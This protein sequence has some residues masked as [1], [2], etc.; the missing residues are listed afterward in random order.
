MPELH[1]I[2]SPRR[3]R[4]GCIEV[5]TSCRLESHMKSHRGEI[6]AAALK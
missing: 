5:R 2:Q 1:R 3:D 4:R 6:A